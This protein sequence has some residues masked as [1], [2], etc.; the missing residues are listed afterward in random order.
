[1]IDDVYVGF[2]MFV[3]FLVVVIVI[4]VIISQRTDV[5]VRRKGRYYPKCKFTKKK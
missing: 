4:D 5:F 3:L 2:I 1:M